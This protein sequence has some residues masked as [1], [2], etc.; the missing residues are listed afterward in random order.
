[1]LYNTPDGT[2]HGG[3]LR[4]T[5]NNP[6]IFRKVD[7]QLSNLKSDGIPVDL[8]ELVIPPTSRTAPVA[9]LR[10]ADG[11]YATGDLL[12]EVAPGLYEYRG[13]NTNFFKL[14]NNRWAPAG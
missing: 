10:D 9:S 11:T 8:Y 1:M 12:E 2:P 7:I 4:Q 14:A 13:R 5:P 3:H 6:L